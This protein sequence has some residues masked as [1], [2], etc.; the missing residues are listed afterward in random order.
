LEVEEKLSLE[1]EKGSRGS[2][3]GLPSPLGERGGHPHSL[4]KKNEE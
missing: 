4:F 3:L 2:S 1:V